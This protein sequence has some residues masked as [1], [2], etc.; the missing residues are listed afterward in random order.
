MNH[1]YRDRLTPKQTKLVKGIIQ[2]KTQQQAALEAGYSP[3]GIDSR[4]SIE[5]KKDKVR[6]ALV[7][8]GLTEESIGQLLAHNITTGAGVKATASDSL[9]GIELYYRAMG[10]LDKEQP[11]QQTTNIFIKELKMMNEEQLQ[12]RLKAIDGEVEELKTTG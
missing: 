11:D 6:R 7:K 3:N 5:I 12:A 10:Y 2:G 9:R 8:A 4:A 1:P